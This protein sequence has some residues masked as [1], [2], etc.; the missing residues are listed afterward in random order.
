MFKFKKKR[1]RKPPSV[2]HRQ[3]SAFGHR[4]GGCIEQFEC[5][6]SKL[7]S[8]LLNFRNQIRRSGAI[9]GNDRSVMVTVWSHRLLTGWARKQ[10]FS[11]C[12]PSTGSNTYVSTK[13][14]KESFCK[15]LFGVPST[16]GRKALQSFSAG[17][18]WREVRNC[19]Q[20]E[21]KN[22]LSLSQSSTFKPNC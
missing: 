20:I 15:S 17:T 14:S 2:R 3:C 21:Q 16:S 22:R 19:P 5:P 18:A 10:I 1:L 7:A 9:S 12:P 13:D 4:S 6:N 11:V 8:K